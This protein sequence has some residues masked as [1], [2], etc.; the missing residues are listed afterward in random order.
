MLKALFLSLSGRLFKSR[1]IYILDE[2]SD[3]IIITIAGDILVS[4]VFSQLKYMGMNI[5]RRLQLFQ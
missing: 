5:C 2:I 4:K 1:W 3:G